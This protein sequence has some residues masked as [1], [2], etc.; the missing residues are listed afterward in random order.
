MENISKFAKMATAR[1]NKENE[2]CCKC[3]LQIPVSTP[4][5]IEEKELQAEHFDKFMAYNTVTKQSI[6][7]NTI[8]EL[9]DKLYDL[10]PD[11][12][13]VEIERLI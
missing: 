3:G 11:P 8:N 13:K 4:L 7:T 6:V 10:S 12:I 5:V 2:T 1:E 9:L